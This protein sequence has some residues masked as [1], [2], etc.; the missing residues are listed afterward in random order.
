MISMDEQ[1]AQQVW[2]RVM[3]VSAPC[4]AKDGTKGAMRSC[5]IACCSKRFDQRN[6]IF[7]P[8]FKMFLKARAGRALAAHS[9]RPLIPSGSGDVLGVC[10]YC[11][12]SPPG[13][14]LAWD[15]ARSSA[16]QLRSAS[17]AVHCS[18]ASL[19]MEIQR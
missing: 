18:Q 4:P 6:D 8:Y 2:S 10:F 1:K 14:E 17:L 9:K 5:S 19:P 12:T 16:A 13:A 15:Q 7:L 3:N 11:M